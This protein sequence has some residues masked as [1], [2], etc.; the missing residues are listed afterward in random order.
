MD[1]MIAIVCLPFLALIAILVII[2]VVKLIK[3][4]IIVGIMLFIM[5]AFLFWY[6][7]LITF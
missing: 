2:G 7:G 6:L 1:P 3:S 4:L 5:F